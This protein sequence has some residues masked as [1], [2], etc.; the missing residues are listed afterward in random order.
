MILVQL[1]G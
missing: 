1:I